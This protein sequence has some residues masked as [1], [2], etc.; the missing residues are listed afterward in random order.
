LGY[1]TSFTNSVQA[2]STLKML[3]IRSHYVVWIMGRYIVTLFEN[4]HLFGYQGTD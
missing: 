1:G 2:G 4:T 3:Y